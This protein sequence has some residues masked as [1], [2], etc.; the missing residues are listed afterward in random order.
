[1][2]SSDLREMT[3]PKVYVPLTYINS[4]HEA[5][6]RGVGDVLTIDNPDPDFPHELMLQIF[7][8]VCSREG[9][10]PNH[11]AIIHIRQSNRAWSLSDK[12]RGELCVDEEGEAFRSAGTVMDGEPFD[13]PNCNW[14][15]AIHKNEVRTLRT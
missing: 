2:Y 8:P 1:M 4:K 5:V 9:R 12:G 7:C 15:A 11:D 10:V 6:M 14:R 3:T 13:C